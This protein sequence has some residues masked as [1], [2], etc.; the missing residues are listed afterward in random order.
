MRVLDLRG[1]ATSAW[2][3]LGTWGEAPQGE[4]GPA[5]DGLGVVDVDV[6]RSERLF[7]AVELRFHLRP[8]HDGDKPRVQR[9]TLCVSNTTGNAELATRGARSAEPPE[10]A[11]WQ[12][13]LDVPFRSQRTED[14]AIAGRICSP[15][16]VSMV[17]AWYG[18]ERPTAEVAARA[19]DAQHDIYGGW[20]R[21]VQAAFEQGLPGY[22]TRFSAW[23][24]VRREIAAGRPVIVSLRAREGEL[25]GAPYESTGGHLVVI[26]GFDERGDVHVNDP[27]TADPAKGVVTYS[28][29][30]MERVWLDRGGVA[31]VL[32]PP[33]S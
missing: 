9:A 29:E 2:Y 22:V 32:L 1:A 15:T 17:L 30:D 19:Y 23:D 5:R 21:A 18:I 12:R 11:L 25:A 27:A 26:T 33:G 13:R 10:P 16:S 24:G 7:D 4:P 31:Y 6:F 3:D 28:R 20:A 8:A 14:P